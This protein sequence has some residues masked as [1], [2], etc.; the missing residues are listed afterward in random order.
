MTNA[1]A[2]DETQ[3]NLILSPFSVSDMAEEAHKMQGKA[4][5]SKNVFSLSAL[6]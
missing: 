3:P 2:L 4:A 1:G 6:P 5:L